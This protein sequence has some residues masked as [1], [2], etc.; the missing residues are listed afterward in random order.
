MSSETNMHSG[1]CILLFLKS[2]MAGQVKTRL[3]AEIGPDAAAG[4]YRCFVEDLISTVDKLD[5]ELKVCFHPP[6]AKSHLQLWLGERH[7][8]MSQTGGDLGQRLKNSFACAFDEGFSKVVAIGSDS[9]DLPERFLREAFEKLESHDAV[10]GPSSDGG[11]Y[12]IGFSKDSLV[13]DVFAGIAWSTSAVFAQTRARLESQGLR[14][15]F[16]PLWHDVDTRPDLAELAARNK[17]TAFT[18]S[19]TF[20]L[21]REFESQ[22]PP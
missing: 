15:H 11:Y 4:L 18:R 10:I 22:L 17:A 13:A 5:G 7:S 12:L 19:R 1:T 6:D 3:A 21:I 9:P 20:A 8:Y 14:V 2:P 16:L